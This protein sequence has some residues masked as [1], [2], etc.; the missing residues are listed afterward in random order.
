MPEID[1]VILRLQAD[2]M[3]YRVDVQNVTDRV[4]RNLDSQAQSMRRLENQFESSSN[5]IKSTLRG[6]AGTLASGVGA[7]QI[8]ALADGYTRF[9]NQLK[10]A[11]LEGSNLAGVQDR[12]F[13]VSQKYGVEL[14]TVGTL[15]SRLAQA[16][17]ELGA[18]QS[19]LLKFTNGVAAALKVQGGSAGEAQGALL[20]LSQALG[21]PIVRAEEFNSINEGARPI[22]QAVASG[23]DKYGGSIAKLR[24]DV[25]AGTVTSRE[26]FQGFLKGS[27]DLEAQA[28]KANFTIGASFTIL[29]NA[30]GRYVGQADGALS[31]TAKFSGAVVS[32]ANNLDVVIPALAGIAAGYGALKVGA[33]AFDGVAAATQRAIGLEREA[34]AQILAGNASYVS[35]TQMAALQATAVREAAAAE[36]AGIEATLA[37]RKQEAAQ[38]A[39]N[40]ALIQQQRA[41]ALLAQKSLAAQSALGFGRIGVTRSSPDAARAN[42]DLKTQIITRRA[43]TAVNAEVAASETA[44]AAAQTRTAVATTA[45]TAAVEA[46]TLSKRAGVAISALFAGTLSTLAGAL[47]ILAIGALVAAVIYYSSAAKKAAFDSEEFKKRGDDLADTTLTINQNARLAASAIATVG[48]NA[49]SS[50]GKMLAFAGAVGEAAA[51][52]KDLAEQR[53]KELIA[54]SKQQEQDAKKDRQDAETRFANAQQSGSSSA[55]FGNLQTPQQAKEQADSL[56]VINEARKREA[57]AIKNREQVEKESLEQRLLPSE[58]ENGRDV[59]GDLARVTRDLAVARERGIKSQVDSLEAQKFELTQYKKYR[60]EGLSPQ[61]AQE[62]SSKDKSDYQSASAGAQ[63]DKDAKA[64][65]RAQKAADRKEATEAAKAAREQIAIDRD[66]YRLTQEELQARLSLATSAD[67]RAKIQTEMLAAERKQRINEVNQEKGLSP[68]QRQAQLDRIATIYGAPPAESGPITVQ[69]G[70]LGKKI[71]QDRQ[72]QL[73][74][75]ALDAAQ[76]A[77]KNDEDLLRGQQALVDSRTARRDIELRLLDIAYEQEKADLDAVIASQASTQAQKDIA[78]KRLDIL[79]QLKASD[80]EG[81]RRDNASPL[82]Q[83]REEVRK[84]AANMGDAVES[85][86]VDAVDRLADGLANASKEY[87]K[88]GGIAGDVINGII[89]DLVKLAVQQAVF[90]ALGGGGGGIIGGIRKTLGFASGGYTGDGP[91]NQVAGVV[92]KGEYVVPAETVKRVGVQ[93]I[94]ALSNSRAAAS[95]SGA[96]A[97]AVRPVQNTI[98]NQ[99]FNLDARHGIMTPQLLQ[100]IEGVR[101]QA[102]QATQSMGTNILKAVPGRL[103]TFQRD[104]T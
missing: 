59:E 84:T 101:Q 65:T 76:A 56:R 16:G 66:N 2:V 10:V 58:R 31:L 46:N 17:K 67:Q 103:A 11:G 68:T 93:N 49:A 83:R 57:Q 99:S 86:E 8:A 52:L 80:A 72:E 12:L 77:S 28:A 102:L 25:I 1:P 48:N 51:R 54:T 92:H 6:L 38:L 70:L 27:A 89:A 36:V 97:V 7:Q 34:T 26:F 4:N 87:I 21:S 41:D 95:M 98:V 32:L 88:L 104:G 69:P 19:D 43:L 91:K 53:K 60:K 5:S 9:T 64:S 71:N 85:I 39:Q 3:R 14:E 42:Q 81:I 63:G 13:D 23:I 24:A 55:R 47:P 15:Y 22:L 78:Q 90:G 94:A 18:G 44:L 74:R 40:L 82:E 100:H 35:R 73:D 75:E 20:Q 45:E 29:N 37:A 96:S 50:A 61:A 30:L 33:L 62:A 79:G